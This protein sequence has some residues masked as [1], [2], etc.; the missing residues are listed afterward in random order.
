MEHLEEQLPNRQK[1]QRSELVLVGVLFL[2]GIGSI[3]FGISRLQ[4][5]IQSPFRI[6]N[7]PDEAPNLLEGVDMQGIDVE[8][9]KTKDTDNDGLSDYQ[10]TYI[11][12]TSVYLN[13]TDGDGISDRE[14][15]SG[16][17]NPACPEGQQCFNGSTAT[18]LPINKNLPPRQGEGPTGTDPAAAINQVVQQFQQKTPEQIRAFLKEQGLSEDQL[19]LVPDAMLQN[20]YAQGL[21]KAVK[22]IQEKGALEQQQ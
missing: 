22:N 11:T 16:G 13:D 18:P 2:F 6:S 19:K 8:G 15:I 4:D 14:E 21:Q 7:I 5:K 17:T 3:I 12:Q 1:A 10:E 9:L 20:I